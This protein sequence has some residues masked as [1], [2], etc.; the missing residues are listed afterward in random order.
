MPHIDTDHL[1]QAYPLAEVVA[2]Y[3]IELRRS[4]RTFIGRC[5]FHADGG[6]PNFHVYVGTQSWYCFRCGVGGDVIRFVQQIEGVGFREAV[7]RLVG[8]SVPA[9]PLRRAASFPAP[10][11]TSSCT[12]GPAERACLAA[13]VELYSNRLFS[14][15]PALAYVTRR[16]LDRSTLEQCRV[17]Y[18]AGDELVAYL[19]WRRLPVQ[20]AVRA[21]LLT[22]R[23]GEF[24]A[25]RIVVPEVRHGQPVWLIGRAIGADERVPRYLALP[26]RKPLLG[27]ETSCHSRWVIVTEGPFDWLT[28]RQWGLPALALV[29]THVRADVLRALC[30]FECIY[31]ALDN[32]EAGHAATAD[33]VQ[34]LGPRAIPLTL[35]DVK[36]V[37]D[38]ALHPRGR[39]AFMRAL[40]QAE[41]SGEVG[42]LRHS[43]PGE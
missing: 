28:L 20:A 36:D 2:R 30:R 9:C 29:G 5:P 1:K 12:W 23:G 41:A 33:L 3:G 27:W 39:K 10:R 37:A 13:A 6:R 24:L 38:L 8:G 34:T 43:I 40:R 22:R 26:G 35:T 31:L 7:E 4:G 16:G 21:G 11:P 18:A 19:R 17:G 32:D 15:P 14:E 42:R 25:G